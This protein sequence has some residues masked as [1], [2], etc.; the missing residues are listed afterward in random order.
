MDKT[1]TKEDIEAYKANANLS[2]N[3]IVTVCGRKVSLN[4][5]KRIP[6]D[7]KIDM[8]KIIEKFCVEDDGMVPAMFSFAF[9][10]TVMLYYTD[11]FN[12]IDAP[13]ADTI[14]FILYDSE[15]WDT[16]YNIVSDDCYS[17]E[18]EARDYVNYV[19]TKS[20]WDGLYGTVESILNEIYDNVKNMHTFDNS[21]MEKIS[22]LVDF[23]SKADSKE[24]VAKIIDFE[25]VKDSVKDAKNADVAPDSRK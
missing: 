20:K 24:S 5:A 25:S 9:R 18:L 10:Y 23:I 19:C 2:C 15:L 16:V 3:A 6:L 14:D 11:L 1:I 21:D 17:I 4:I 7:K 12:I 22:A 13:D 8:V